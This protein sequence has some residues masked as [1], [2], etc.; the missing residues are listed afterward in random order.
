MR[1][2]SL[3]AVIII[4]SC[5][6]ASSQKNWKPFLGTNISLSADGYY[7]GPSFSVGVTHSIGKKKKW[8]WAPEVTYFR[9][10]S[11]YPYSS[12]VSEKDKFESFSVRSNFNY[13]I[14]KKSGRGFFIGGGIGFQRASDEC[15]TITQNGSIKEVNVHYDA[16]KYGILTATF[17]TGY[18][19]PL[20]KDK[21]IQVL[22]SA[23]GPH[24]AK[25]YLGTYVEVIS[26]LS[27]GARI[28]L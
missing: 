8:S 5:L 9:R 14:G 19:F 26:V 12:T 28:V 17:N 7:V 10:S 23:I 24:T 6:S 15:W 4:F 22:I 18:T 20:K 21:S 2:L 11:T 3:I 16:I 25:D 13:Q 27:I 1:K